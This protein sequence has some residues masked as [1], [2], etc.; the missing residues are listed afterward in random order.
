[1]AIELT[2]QSGAYF[3]NRATARLIDGDERS[4][5]ED[6]RKA[7]AFDP[8]EPFVHLL[9]FIAQTRAGNKEA[10]QSALA[11]YAENH[12]KQDWPRPIVDLFLGRGSTEAVEKAAKIA[13]Q[14]KDA[15]GQ[16]FDADF[17]IG[18]WAL[19]SG[20]EA[21]ATLRLKSVYDS[22]MREYLEFDIARA[23]LN[24][25]GTLANSPTR[26]PTDRPHQNVQT[27]SKR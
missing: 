22:R 26:I 14:Q 10:A 27:G 8:E 23:D 25:L 1:H 2:P 21:A 4:A 3:A 6:F 7:V 20:D 15:A 16:R 9:L 11:T 12:P 13:A 5:V 17:Y 24:S 19:L 18:Q